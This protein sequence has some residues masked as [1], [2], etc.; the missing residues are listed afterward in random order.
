M[1]ASRTKCERDLNGMWMQSERS[2]NAMAT[3][4]I[5]DNFVFQS[6][7]MLFTS[8]LFSKS[9]CLEIRL[10]LTIV[11]RFL[12]EYQVYLHEIQWYFKG[13]MESRRFLRC[14]GGVAWRWFDV[15]FWRHLDF[16]TLWSDTFFVCITHTFN[17]YIYIYLHTHTLVYIYICVCVYTYRC[18]IYTHIY[19]SHMIINMH[20][21][22]KN[23]MCAV[24]IVIYP[25]VRV[26][27]SCGSTFRRRRYAED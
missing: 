2:A 9:D 18:I 13:S 24:C 11:F 27:F 7:V 16:K 6:G 3:L 10:I 8:T 17:I 22:I 26:V 25:N 12:Q 5:I 4:F 1:D 21:S 19:I 14:I 23:Y 15:S 20:Y